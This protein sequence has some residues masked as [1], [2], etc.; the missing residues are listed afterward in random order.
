[1]LRFGGNDIRGHNHL[2]TGGRLIPMS[3]CPPPPPKHIFRI[4]INDIR[5]SPYPPCAPHAPFVADHPPSLAI[6]EYYYPYPPP[7][8]YVFPGCYYRLSPEFRY[9][10]HY[11]LPQRVIETTKRKCKYKTKNILFLF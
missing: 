3:N 11:G 8:P 5:Y 4:P 10:Q 6:P 1:M 9:P 2:E 7:T